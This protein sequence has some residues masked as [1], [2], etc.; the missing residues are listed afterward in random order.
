MSEN[1]TIEDIEKKLRELARAIK[2]TLQMPQ[3]VYERHGRIENKPLDVYFAELADRIEAAHKREVDKLN[4]VIQAQRSAFDAEQDRQRRAAPGNMA[5]LREAVVNISRYAECAAM[6]Q[7]DAQTQEYIDQIHKWAN[8]ALKEPARNC[9]VDT[10]AEQSDRYEAHCE[11]YHKTTGKCDDCPIF[12]EECK[13][14]GSIPHCQ[15]VWAQMPYEA[16][17]GGAK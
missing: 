4:S 5:K 2:H 1:E 11:A 12:K 6:R 14:T 15:L 13:M 10:A 8:A 9:D 7:H 17:E 3:A 16:K